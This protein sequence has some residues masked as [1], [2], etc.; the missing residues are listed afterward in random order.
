MLLV[1]FMFCLSKSIQNLN[2]KLN[3]RAIIQI[4]WWEVGER[5]FHPQLHKL[6]GKI[7]IFIHSWSSINRQYGALSH[8]ILISGWRWWWW[9]VE[10]SSVLGWLRF[11]MFSR[12]REN[13]VE[14]KCENHDGCPLGFVLHLENL[15]LILFLILLCGIPNC[16]FIFWNLTPGFSRKS[17]T[18]FYINPHNLCILYAINSVN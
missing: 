15:L 7:F 12:L 10:S 18:S 5:M 3:A 4:N 16:C 6:R 14:I 13:F 1:S 2:C 8:W 9:R 11:M 17:S